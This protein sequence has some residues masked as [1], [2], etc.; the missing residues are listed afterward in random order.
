METNKSTSYS[1]IFVI[2]SAEFIFLLNSTGILFSSAS[3][4][5]SA[6]LLSYLTVTNFIFKVLSEIIFLKAL[7]PQGPSAKYPISISHTPI[8]K[9]LHQ[10][11]NINSSI[12]AADRNGYISCS[13]GV[14]ILPFSSNLDIT[15]GVTG[16]SNF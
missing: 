11:L 9:S 2:N 5:S 7:C 1:F 13:A 6:S 10:F 16:S 4:N 15:L 12:S 14:S 3:C 8:K